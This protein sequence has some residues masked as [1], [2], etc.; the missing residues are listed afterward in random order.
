MGVM[1]EGKREKRYRPNNLFILAG[2]PLN[3]SA[4]GLTEKTHYV[5][6]F[7]CFKAQFRDQSLHFRTYIVI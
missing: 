5:N 4:T 3:I 7:Y 6:M 1:L 2:I